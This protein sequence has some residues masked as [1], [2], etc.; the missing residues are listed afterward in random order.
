MQ[1]ISKALNAIDDVTYTKENTVKCNGRNLRWDFVVQ[2]GNNLFHIESDGEQHFSLKANMHMSRII[3]E[4][5]GRKHFADQRT[6]DL[7]KDVRIRNMKGLLFRV[8]YRQLKKLDGL[9]KEMIQK[10]NEGAKGVVYMDRK[11]YANWEP[12]N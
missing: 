2:N 3:D 11:L 10:S 5:K 1:A 9:V 12:I 6:K 8:S 7:L 4:D